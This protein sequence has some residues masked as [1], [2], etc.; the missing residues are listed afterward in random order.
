MS[1]ARQSCDGASPNG[2]QEACAKR[3]PF[4]DVLKFF[5]MLLVVYWHTAGAFESKIGIPYVTNF[6]V[7]VNMPLFFIISG[8]FASRTIENGDW[9]KLGLRMTSYFWP[10]ATISMFFSALTQVFQLKGFENGFI[11]CAGRSFLF[12]PWFLW[13][14]AICFGVTFLCRRMGRSGMFYVLLCFV[15]C[16]LLVD[17]KV[18]HL[19]NVR[20]MLPF[21]LIG[22]Y[23]LRKVD[24]SKYWFIGLPCMC[25][26]LLIVFIQ[27]QI[28]TNGLSFYHAGISWKLILNDRVVILYTLA[29]IA[30]GVIGC[31][32]IM[33]CIR[34]VMQKEKLLGY[35]APLGTTTLGVYLLHQWILHRIPHENMGWGGGVVFDNYSFYVLSCDCLEHQAKPNRQYCALG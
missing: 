26:Y 3:D 14:L 19:G 2:S 11:G 30:N 10:M 22:A 23:V 32:G 31:I 24:L 6:I 7:G 15:Y 5:A 16:F 4:W 17:C 27:G 29:R 35:L 34:V 33:W 21:F 9:R 20:A 13:C 25:C 8:Y 12:G 28:Q 18:W 1:A